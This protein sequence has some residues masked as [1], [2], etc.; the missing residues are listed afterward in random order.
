MSQVVTAVNEYTDVARDARSSC[1][2]TGARSPITFREIASFPRS[3]ERPTRGG[4]HTLTRPRTKHKTRLIYTSVP[5]AG[6]RAYTL[7]RR[8]YYSAHRF[9]YRANRH[10]TA[11]IRT[12]CAGSRRTPG[13]GRRRRT[14]L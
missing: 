1:K 13:A 3:P 4:R 5:V 14:R 2:S 11:T 7:L 6:S 9:D 12:D 10:N 8:A